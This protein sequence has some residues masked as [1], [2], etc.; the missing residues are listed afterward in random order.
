MTAALHFVPFAP[1]N[2]AI[3]G[4]GL[5][6]ISALGVQSLASLVFPLPMPPGEPGALD[7]GAQLP[8]AL[9]AGSLR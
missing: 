5:G 1:L 3:Y 7:G 9:P 4:C 2:E 6:A 8:P